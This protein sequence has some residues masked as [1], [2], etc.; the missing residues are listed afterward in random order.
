[1]SFDFVFGQ[2]HL[3]SPENKYIGLFSPIDRDVFLPDMPEDFSLT[4]ENANEK[5]FEWM[6][7]DFYN[8]GDILI[9]TNFHTL[10]SLSD[11]GYKLGRSVSRMNAET[12]K[13][14][15]APLQAIDKKTK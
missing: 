2:P 8:D 4:P 7:D 5:G 9:S 3:T 1:M 13:G 6:Y 10:R 12:Q 15:Y 14:V 11:E